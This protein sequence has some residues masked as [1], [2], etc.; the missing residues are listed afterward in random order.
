[1]RRIVLLGAL[2]VAMV[3]AAAV[4][5]AGK[6]LAYGSGSVAQVEVSGNCDDVSFC[7]ASPFGGTG[8]LWIWASLNNDTNHSVDATFIGCGHQ[9]GGGGSHAGFGGNGPAPVEGTWYTAP[10]VFTAAFVDRALPLGIAM[11]NPTTPDLSVPYY[12]IALNNGFTYAVP[13]RLGHYNYSGIQFI[14]GVPANM[15]IPG[16]SFQTQVAP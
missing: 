13:E 1:M 7:D 6:A 8:G 2:V 14:A 16:V 3:V 12:V 11:V 4:L 5:G 15:K 10:D 9:V